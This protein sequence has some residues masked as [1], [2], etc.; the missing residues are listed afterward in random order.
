MAGLAPVKKLRIGSDAPDFE[1]EYSTQGPIR[2][3]DYIGNKWAILLFYPDD[4]TPVATTELIILSCL[5]KQLAQRN[6][7]LLA[8]S[9][10]NRTTRTARGM[11]YVSHEKW[12]QDVDDI[13]PTPMKFPIV[14]DSEGLISRAYNVLDD[15]DVD[16]INASGVKVVE[17]P[18]FKSRTLLIIGPLKRNGKHSIRF[19][20]NYPAAVGFSPEVLRVVDALQIADASKIRTPANWIGGDVIVP[21]SVSDEEAREKFPNFK[22]VKPYLRFVELPDDDDDE[23]IESYYFLKGA[24]VS[25]SSSLK[26]GKPVISVGETEHAIEPIA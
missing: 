4:F 12:V 9:T 7:K 19:I 5:Q 26:N 20:L 22:P 17:G 25:I 11:Q 8:V 16:N 2:F 18:A 1:S 15:S 14:Q 3:Y 10:Q 24:L 6:V 21:K 13:S 23:D